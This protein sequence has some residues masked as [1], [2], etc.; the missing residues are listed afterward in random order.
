[1]SKDVVLTLSLVFDSAIVVV[2]LT[3]CP[4]SEF[5]PESY[6]K[7]PKKMRSNTTNAGDLEKSVVLYAILPGACP[8]CPRIL[9]T[10]Q[11]NGRYDQ[12]SSPM[13]NLWA[14]STTLRRTT[15]CLRRTT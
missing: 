12:C 2:S 15:T 11:T 9:T 1:M 5:N 14:S 8:A 13:E 3:E 7:D 10:S 4:D 6:L